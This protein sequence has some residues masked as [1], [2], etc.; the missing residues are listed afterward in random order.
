M[1][2]LITYTIVSLLVSFIFVVPLFMKRVRSMTIW[3]TLLQFFFVGVLIFYVNLPILSWWTS[4]VVIGFC[5]SLP[6]AMKQYKRESGAALLN[7]AAG[8]F[9]G[10][11]IA[12]LK[13]QLPTLA[14]YLA[15]TA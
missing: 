2:S 13:V 4:G 14:G 12:L 11:V 15:A 9:H 1:K 3:A 10:F 5:L 6:S 7:L 8:A